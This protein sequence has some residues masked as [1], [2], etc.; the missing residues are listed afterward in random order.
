MSENFPPS[1]TR[2][3]TPRKQELFQ[4]QLESIL[5][6]NVSLENIDTYADAVLD[7]L[8]ELTDEVTTAYKETGVTTA[9]LTDDALEN[10]AY[11]LFGLSSIGSALERAQEIQQT[12]LD[13]QERISET[14]IGESDAFLIP[15]GS[16]PLALGNGESTFTEKD[17]IPRL[18]TLLF[19]LESDCDINPEEIGITRGEVDE[20]WFRE[21]PYY[22]VEVP[23]LE[24]AVYVCEEEGNASYIFDTGLL[25]EIG[26]ELTLLDHA[27]KEDLN[28]IIA[29]L[30]GIGMRVIQQPAWREVMSTYLLAPMQVQERSSEHI[31]G[32][33]DYVVA[34]VDDLDP[35]KGFHTDEA[36][37][38]WGTQAAIRNKLGIKQ[39]KFESILRDNNQLTTQKI[40]SIRGSIYDAY[41]IEDVQQLEEIKQ[42]FVTPEVSVADSDPFKGF[43]ED[44]E[45]NH[46]STKNTLAKQI[47]INPS[48]LEQVIKSN[49][50]ILTT[51]TIKDLLNRVTV[52][53]CL[54]QL[55]PLVPEEYLTERSSLNVETS[56]E[57]AG[58]YVDEEGR[59]WGSSSVIAKKLNLDTSNTHKLLS[60]SNLPTRSVKSHRT[61]TA[62]CLEDVLDYEPIKRRLSEENRVET[63]GEWAG[64]YT[65]K[66]GK[67]W[68]SALA[69]GQKT[70]LH[71]SGIITFAKRNKLP[72]TSII[73][74]ANQTSD[75]YCYED[76][77]R[78]QEVLPDK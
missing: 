26:V 46:W 13:I 42:E 68:A 27:S 48:Q 51:R 59:H 39:G 64:F 3:D 41:C 49:N 9:N 30:P 7:A 14:A 34:S 20:R 66:N 40:R 63:S 37:K 76:I 18:K 60:E 2:P 19:L 22:R 8:I 10:S 50:S 61:S 71:Y 16:Q 77:L 11:E 75:G 73:N 1:H 12:I 62:Y 53:Y 25:G 55:I 65:D 56:G 70:G 32:E 45:Y 33:P 78:F 67:H 28:A 38:H 58:F 29:E 52:G 74:R 54:E 57:W 72:I 24:R 36:G 35:W 4:N 69:I 5:H 15:P 17:I 31:E 23:S 43:W 44:E 6:T 21:E 47:G